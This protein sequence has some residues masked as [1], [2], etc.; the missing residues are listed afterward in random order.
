MLD[1]CLEHIAEADIF[2]ACAAVADYRPASAAEQ[3]IKKNDNELTVTFVRNPD[4]VATIAAQKP[5]PF[6]VGF[7]A[8]TEKLREHARGKLE[9]KNLDLI[10]ANDVSDTSIGFNSDSNAALLLWPGG[11]TSIER[12][13]KDALARHLIAHIAE[14][15]QQGSGQ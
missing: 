10:V 2:I 13:S 6:V 11:E 12:C 1:A 9:R 7:A 14:R 3:K 5:R 15:L 8:E 4:I